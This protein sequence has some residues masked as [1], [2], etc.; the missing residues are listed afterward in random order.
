MSATRISV[1]ASVTDPPTRRC[2][3]DGIADQGIAKPGH[4]DVGYR[5][6]HGIGTGRRR[7]QVFERQD[8]LLV[9]LPT[10]L[11]GDEVEL[12]V[13]DAAQVEGAGALEC[14]LLQV[15]RPEDTIDHGRRRR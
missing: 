5:N 6:F 4:V 11:L 12:E 1:S 3:C 7:W 9:E 2:S 8:R 14:R 15:V 10:H 13:V